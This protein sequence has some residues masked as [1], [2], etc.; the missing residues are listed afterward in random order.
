MQFRAE[1]IDMYITVILTDISAK[2]ISVLSNLKLSNEIK[3]LL[4]IQYFD[5]ENGES[6]AMLTQP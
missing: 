6:N 1:H 2:N 3:L 4:P 5:V